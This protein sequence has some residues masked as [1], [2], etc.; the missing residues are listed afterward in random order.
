MKE[1][2]TIP[3][4]ATIREALQVIDANHHGIVLVLDA[5]QRVIGTAT[6]GDIRRQLLEGLTLEDRIEQCAEPNFVWSPVGE[7]RERLLKLLDHRVKLI[8][9]LDSDRRL[10]EVIARDHFPLPEESPVYVR[11][12]APVRISFGG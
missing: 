2:I 6:D 7:S 10:V 5:T 3:A 4:Q 11:A 8:P 1:R 9:L 12:R